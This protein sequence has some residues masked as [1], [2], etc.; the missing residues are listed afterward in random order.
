[1]L[2][3]GRLGLVRLA[4]KFARLVRLGLI[5]FRFRRYSFVGRGPNVE[6]IN[7]KN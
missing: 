5:P 7:T 2:G 3:F 6:K 1:M 4:P